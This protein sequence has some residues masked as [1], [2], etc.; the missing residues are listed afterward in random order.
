MMTRMDVPEPSI[1]L[2]FRTA[3]EN[4]IAPVVKL[5]TSAY[6][7]ETSRI[8]WTTEAD[9]LDGG[10]IDAQLLL[11]DITRAHS[12]VVLAEH[13]DTR[14]LI[15]CAHLAEEDGAGYFG[16]FAVRPEYQGK[17][18]G[19]QLLTEAE[20]IIHADWQLPIMRMT[21]IDL[22]H[23]LIAFYERRGYQRTGRYQP[24]PYGDTRFGLP[25]RDNLRF[26][27]L[28]KQ[29]CASAEEA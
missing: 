21:V 28:E 6:R 8:G 27:V 14:E 4:D 19:K 16:M 17:G 1:P 25:R 22:R 10:R 26:E 23:E 24:F 20:H 5:V 9:F 15:A 29:F 12:R 3:T 7:G 11:N 2:K 13:R 18:V